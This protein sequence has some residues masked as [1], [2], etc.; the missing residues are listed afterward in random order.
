[1]TQSL[2]HKTLNEPLFL[3]LNPY[4]YHLS[5]KEM[6]ELSEDHFYDDP[7]LDVVY[8]EFYKHIYLLKEINNRIDSFLQI[9][10]YRQ[11][12]NYNSLLNQIRR[13]N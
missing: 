2:L 9:Y 5:E 10:D 3:L 8:R 1:M 7:L 4:L 6:L 13:I 11:H 12:I